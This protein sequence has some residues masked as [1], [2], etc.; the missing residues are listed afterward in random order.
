MPHTKHG[1]QV[2]GP[3]YEEDM[4]L[5]ESLQRRAAK[6]VKGL[7]TKMYEGYLK[8][9]GLFNPEQ[10]RLRGGLMA[11]QE[12]SGGAALSSAL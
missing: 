12:G 2:W 3:Q 11:P 8:S 6:M 7:E 5:L 10:R 9:L 1:V 4:K